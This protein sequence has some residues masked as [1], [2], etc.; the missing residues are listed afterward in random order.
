MDIFFLGDSMMELLEC[1]EVLCF[2][3]LSQVVWPLNT[4]IVCTKISIL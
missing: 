2:A 1:P 4:F 3:N